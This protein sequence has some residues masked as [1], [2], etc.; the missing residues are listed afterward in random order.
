MQTPSPLRPDGTLVPPERFNFV[1][2]VLQ[3]RAQATPDAVAVIGVGRSREVDTWSYGRMAQACGRVAA[4]LVEHGVKRGDRVLIF[5]TRT[6][7]WHVAMA[8]CLHIGAIPV[9]CV[10][11]VSA[12]EV[13]Y[14]AQQ[15]GARAAIASAELTPRFEGWQA[16]LEVRIATG[17]VPGWLDLRALIERPVAAPPVA[18]MPAETPA[19]MYFTSGS[20][21]LPKAVVHAARG[22]YVRGWQ[23]WHQLGAGPG[24]VIW[25]TSDTGWTRAGSCLM[26]GAW[27]HG[28]TALI[29]EPQLDADERVEMLRRHRVTIFGAVATEL[30]QIIAE[31]QPRPL[32]DLRWT[33]SAGEAMTA[34]LSQRWKAFSGTPLVVG[35]GQT[36]TPTSTLTDPEGEAVNG[37]IGRPMAGN[38]LTVL[39]ADGKAA[40]PGVV[41]E[42]AFAGDH[43]GLMLGYWQDGQVVRTFER[44]GWHMTG[45][46]GSLDAQGNL[47]FVGRSD[48]I[49]S[50]SGYRIGPTEVENALTRHPAVLEC[51]VTASP[52]PMRGEVVKA[53]VILRP[54]HAAGE[55]LTEE[56]QAFVRQEIAPYKYPRRI[57]YVADLPRTSSGK[58]SRRLLRDAEFARGADRKGPQG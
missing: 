7:L 31:A 47:F 50:S 25:T 58:I 48:D 57:E 51:A 40:A 9:P 35:Y 29:V 11:Q 21:G 42:I 33:L 12:S 17:A 46:T 41:G 45:D 1:S 10:T 6:P 52:D 8:A 5:M 27:T 18:S 53:F 56:L 20:S 14:R 19:L 13:R 28:A 44:D 4:A 2:D 23:P 16:E 26:F 15:S 38:P 49:I 32:P 37:M 24:D 36:E 55:R 39:D 22:V 3:T 43:P 30:R 34:E 54:G